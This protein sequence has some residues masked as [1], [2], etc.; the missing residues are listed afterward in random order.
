MG[1]YLCILA[2]TINFWQLSK[3]HKDW[4]HLTYSSEER[5]YCCWVEGTSPINSDSSSRLIQEAKTWGRLSGAEW[6]DTLKTHPKASAN[7]NCF[8]F[9]IGDNCTIAPISPGFSSNLQ[10]FTQSTLM[11]KILTNASIERQNLAPPLSGTQPGKQTS[12]LPGWCWTIK[13]LSAPKNY[14][15]Q[16]QFITH[17]CDQ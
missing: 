3:S 17:K 11:L 6:H 7:L 2:D 12:S 10:N 16:R 13:E 8:S 14:L 9:Y 15:H 4:H 5:V 1:Q